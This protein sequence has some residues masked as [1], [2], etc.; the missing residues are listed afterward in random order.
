MPEI[1][2]IA[3]DIDGTIMDGNFNIS[4]RVKSVVKKAIDAGIYVVLA[5][6]RMYSATVPIADELGIQ[7]RLSPIRA[8]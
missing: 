5:T 7:L 4:D 3:L 2:L 8:V 1:K 6:G